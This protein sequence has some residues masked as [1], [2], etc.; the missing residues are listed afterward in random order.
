SLSHSS[1]RLRGPAISPRLRLPIY[2]ELGEVLYRF[3]ALSD[4]TMIFVLSGDPAKTE[5]RQTT[6]TLVSVGE[7]HFF[8]LET[9]PDV[10]QQH[11]R[12]HFPGS[13]FALVGEHHLQVPS[14][15]FR[16]LQNPLR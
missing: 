15:G 6:V 16:R 12:M 3:I 4:Q 9:G 8:A 7:H 1:F 13:G 11:E 2:V 14:G 10:S 5:I